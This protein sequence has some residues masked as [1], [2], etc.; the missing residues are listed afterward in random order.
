MNK[1]EHKVTHKHL[2]ISAYVN[3][4]PRSEEALVEWLDDLVKIIDMN[5]LSGPTAKYVN[6]EGNRGVTGTVMIE[7]SHISIHIWDEPEPA[8]VQFDVYSCKDFNEQDVVDHLDKF[9]TVK[10][11]SRLI[12]RDF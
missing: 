5:K 10:I 4:P 12:D 7:T 11:S 3:E 6:K 9:K 2:L 8:L 1:E